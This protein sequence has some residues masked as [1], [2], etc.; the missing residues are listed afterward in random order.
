VRLSLG[1]AWLVLAL[2]LALAFNIP[3]VLTLE[4]AVRIFRERGFDLLLADAQ[5]AAA[6]ADERAAGA[7]ANPQLSGSVGKSF[8][9][10]AMAWGAGISDPS[11]LSDL[12]SGKRGLRLDVARAAL[13]AARRSREDA[14]RTL[15]LQLKQAMLD[16]ALQQA[17]REF[18]REMAESA[19]HTRQ[20]DEARLAAGAISEAELAKAE[21]AA[22]QAEQAVDLAAQSLLAARLQIA[23]LLGERESVA[24]FEVDRSLLERPLPA[25]APELNALAQEALA[26][27]PDLLAAQRQEERAGAAVALA[28][29]QRI[30]EV[31]LSLNY[32]EQGAVQPPT[33]SFGAQFPLPIFYLQQGEIAK[34]EADLRS[35]RVLREKARAQ[36]LL[37]V[38]TS[39]AAVDANRKLVERMRGRLLDRA[40]RARDLVQVQYEKGAASLLELLDAQRTWTQIHA[41][42]LKDLRDFWLSTFQL[43]AAVGRT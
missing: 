9:P 7:V 14:L 27:R 32:M 28:R 22:L 21:V 12:I 8:D 3:P 23:F 43:D 15:S 20:L 30:P 6:Q 35:Q 16:G 17:Q 39:R 34:A 11:A 40:R 24:E 25:P 18:A 33:I 13:A 4:D 26:N 38:Q 36:V 42:Y 2:A 10:S 29:Q 41:E 31:S 5:V 37:E 1:K 19:N